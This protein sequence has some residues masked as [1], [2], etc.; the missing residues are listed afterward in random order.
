MAV[1]LFHLPDCQK[2]A[3]RQHSQ[4]IGISV[5]EGIRQAIG[6]WLDK[7]QDSCGIVMSGI[8]ISGKIMSIRIGS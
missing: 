4:S 3:L 7:G 8:L 2:E 1:V 6:D 5:S